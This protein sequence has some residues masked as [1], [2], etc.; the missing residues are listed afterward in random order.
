MGGTGNAGNTVRG[1]PDGR[2]ARPR[3]AT[4]EDC[5]EERRDI[6]QK[7]KYKMSF[8]KNTLLI[9]YGFKYLSYDY[10]TEM[11]R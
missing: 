8:T 9:G 2:P 3:G 5:V 10:T 6:L 4:R 11:F 1:C 7:T